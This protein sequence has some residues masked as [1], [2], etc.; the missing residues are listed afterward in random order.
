MRSRRRVVILAALT[1]AISACLAFHR[2]GANSIFA[3]EAIFANIA[4]TAVVDGQWYPLYNGGVRY[5]SKPPLAIWPMALRFKV[6]GVSEFNTR[7]GSALAGVLVSLLLFALG[8]WLVDA[9][10]GALAALLLISAPPWLLEHGV[11]EGVGDIWTTL[12]IGVA[13]VSYVRARIVESRGLLLTTVAAT[14]A[15]SLIKG[16]IVFVVL[17]MVGLCWELTAQLL[18]GRRPRRLLLCAIVLVSAIP[19]ALWLAD[20][21]AHDTTAQTRLWSQFI[22]RHTAA[23]D[24][25]HVQ[26]ALFYPRVLIHAFGWWL[27]ALLLPLLW[28]WLRARETAL[29]LPLWSFL[30]IAAFSLSVSKLPWYLDPALPPLALLIAI[31]IYL[32]LS[33]VPSLALRFALGALIVGAVALRLLGAW[34]AVNATPRQTDMHRLVLAYRSA[35][36]PA[37]YVDT[38]EPPSF[39]YREWNYFY[40]N[41]LPREA[42]TIPATIDHS[43]CSAIVTMHPEPLLRRADFAG[44]TTRQLH[45]YDPREADL[46]VIDLCGGRFVLP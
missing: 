28:R 42:P 17:L 34:N 5:V 18:H 31:A 1:A 19:F 14:I 3:D 9:Y 6:G 30:P 25:T 38:S 7:I 8:T 27:L 2:L 33:H 12:F 45:K 15:G 10:A 22:T 21:A 26:N 40:L 41:L 29:L 43:R 13:L 39:R 35:T 44:A 46:Y 32:G 36:R 23:I 20:N 24:P 37:L 4:R 11:R 16:P